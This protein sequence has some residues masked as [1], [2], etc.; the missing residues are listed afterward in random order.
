M[1]GTVPQVRNHQSRITDSYNRGV[2]KRQGSGLISRLRAGSSPASATISSR[3]HSNPFPWAARSSRRSP[4]SHAGEQGATPWRSTNF[5]QRREGSEPRKSHKLPQRGA[6]P[7][8]ATTFPCVP[9]DRQRRGL[10][11]KTSASGPAR[12]STWTAHQFHAFHARPVS[13]AMKSARL[14]SG[15]S[16]EQCPHRPPISPSINIACERAS[17][18]ASLG[19][20]RRLGQH[21]GTRPVSYPHAPRSRGRRD[22]ASVF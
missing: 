12:G 7:R 19:T 1:Q 14:S 10:V 15:G 20:R 9:V 4:A 16:R 8:P 13:S 22:E 11:C 17:E 18:L 21:Q 3:I 6:T 2:A 5:K